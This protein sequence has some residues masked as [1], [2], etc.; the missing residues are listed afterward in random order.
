MKGSPGLFDARSPKAP[1]RNNTMS[2]VASRQVSLRKVLLLGILLGVL[3]FA[4]LP[5]SYRPARDTAGPRDP[6]PEGIPRVVHLV[7]LKASD[8]A[9]LHFSFQS[10]LCVY[11]AHLF[12]QPTKI[13][14]HTD[15]DASSVD[16]AIE[17]GSPWTRM[18]LTAFPGIVKINPVVPPTAAVNGLTLER[19]EHKSDFVRMEQVAAHGGIYL[20]WDVLTLRPPAPLLDAGFAAVVGRQ[21]DG[22]INNGC[23]MATRRSAL[24]RLMNQEMP[25][26]FSGEWQHHSTGLITPIAERIARVPG[27]VLILDHKAFAPTSWVDES[28]AQLYSEH[29]EEG[30]SLIRE[31]SGAEPIGAA[32]HWSSRTTDADW[33]IDFSQTYFLHAF[34]GLWS[35]VPRFDGISLPY[36]LR[37]K[38]NYAL[39][40]WPVV[41]QAIRDGII[42]EEDEDLWSR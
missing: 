39:A 38:S 7:Q 10:F 15:H 16:R 27:E 36:V 8:D 40:A 28:A 3:I 34:K 11:S 31:Q 37:R 5:D 6:R 2:T 17:G 26:V 24:V 9:E 14:I 13:L 21:A 22:N 33:E 29:D 25:V 20:D 18:V 30:R 23:F 1:E 19:I 12:I 32:E 4:F 42:D 35:P 41:M